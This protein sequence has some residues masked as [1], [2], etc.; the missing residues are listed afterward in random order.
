MFWQI[1]ESYYKLLNGKDGKVRAA[2]I[3]VTG[4]EGKR[5]AITLRRLIQLLIPIELSSPSESKK[6]ESTTR[7][8]NDEAEECALGRARS[9][10]VIN[11]EKFGENEL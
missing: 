5:N 3:Q 9:E 10:A 8:L 2:E 1:S 6:V 7:D 4:A 11:T